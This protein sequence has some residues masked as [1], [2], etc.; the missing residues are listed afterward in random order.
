MH[1]SLWRV[2][3]SANLTSA[4]IAICCQSVSMKRVQLPLFSLARRKSKHPRS[5]ET[6]IFPKSCDVSWETKCLT[7]VHI[8]SA[9]CHSCLIVLSHFPFRMAGIVF[10][11]I[12]NSRR[13][14]T[15]KGGGIMTLHNIL[16]RWLWCKICGAKISGWRAQKLLRWGGSKFSFTSNA[17]TVR[18]V[19]REWCLLRFSELGSQKN[20]ATW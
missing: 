12:Q 4:E 16:R 15:L 10:W 5:H 13:S 6:C 2:A 11:R 9:L 19:H 7:N 17:T 1:Q 8:H 20:P 14:K 3:R 18:N